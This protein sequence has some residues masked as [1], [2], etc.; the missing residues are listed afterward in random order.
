MSSTPVSCLVT[1]AGTN[2]TGGTLG[3]VAEIGNGRLR[4]AR[5]RSFAT[6]ELT[7]AGTL[8]GGGVASKTGSSNGDCIDRGGAEAAS[9]EQSTQRKNNGK[10]KVSIKRTNSKKSNLNGPTNTQ[11]N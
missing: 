11:V 2:T 7:A 5:A 10:L 8:E 4:M 6:E 9:Y 1:K 3:S